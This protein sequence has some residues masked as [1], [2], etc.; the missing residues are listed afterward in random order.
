[1]K[2]EDGGYRAIGP[3]LGRF[4]GVEEL[5]RVPVTNSRGELVGEMLAS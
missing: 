2:A 3:A 4:L 5:A 1:M